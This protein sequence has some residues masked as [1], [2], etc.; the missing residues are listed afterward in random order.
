MDT[1][2]FDPKAFLLFGLKHYG[3][4]V[5]A[6]KGRHIQLKHEYEVEIEGPNLY[7][8]IHQGMVVAPFGGVEELCE[9]VV[10]D[11]QLNYG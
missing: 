5:I 4:E 11:I 1:S 2:T 8:L 9:F 3:L 10:Q 7:K 6:E